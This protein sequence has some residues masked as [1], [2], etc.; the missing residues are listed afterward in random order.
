GRTFDWS[1]VASSRL[2][3]W[4]AGGLNPQNVARAI[5]VVQPDWVD[6]SSGVEDEPGS[7]NHEKIRGLIRQ[8]TR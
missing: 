8:V 4:L 1:L 7:K 5:A 2:P 6:V 3:V